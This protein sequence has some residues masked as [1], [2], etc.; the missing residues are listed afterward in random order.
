MCSVL[1]LPPMLRAVSSCHMYYLILRDP[2]RKRALVSDCG[3]QNDGHV[4]FPRAE[5]PLPFVADARAAAPAPG[6]HVDA[7]ISFHT[8]LA[9]SALLLRVGG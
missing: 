8:R 7:A 4:T 3:M 6:A 5:L 1:R 2:P 9:P